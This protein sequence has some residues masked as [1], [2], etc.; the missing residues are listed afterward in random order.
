MLILSRKSDESIVIG[1][2]IVVKV[3]SIDRGSV[4]LGFEAPPSTL[5]LRAE[6]KEA[7]ASENKKASVETSNEVIDH[8]GKHILL[9]KSKD[10]EK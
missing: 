10:L 7:V 5:I 8:I 1:E 2:N 3:I 9:K 4:K 6:L